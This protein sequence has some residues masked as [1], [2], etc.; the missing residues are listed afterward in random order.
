MYT[1]YILQD[2]KTKGY[3]IGSTNDL[4]RRLDEH[5]RNHVQS[6][7]AKGPWKLV[8]TEIFDSLSE[9]RSREFAIK[10]KKRKSYINWLI[11]NK[12]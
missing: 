4:N 3:Y 2:I 6:T 8:Y 9:A 1:V 12:K 7:R 11:E 10:K 5:F